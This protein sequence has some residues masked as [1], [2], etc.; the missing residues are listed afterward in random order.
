MGHQVKT[1][2]NDN[3]V[4]GAFQQHPAKLGTIL[5]HYVIGPFQIDDH[6]RCNVTH[7]VV[8]RDCR[9]EGKAGRCRIIW[10]NANDSTGKK[11]ADRAFPGSTEATTATILGICTKP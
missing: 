4:T 6:C 3:R 1:N 2:A 8:N 7:G 11:V 5:S 10:L 9:N